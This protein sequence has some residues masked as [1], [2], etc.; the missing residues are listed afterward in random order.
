MK[1]KTFRM[2]G[3][4]GDKKIDIDNPEAEKTIG[5]GIAIAAVTAAALWGI[6]KIAKIFKK[7]KSKA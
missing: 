1:D 3:E 7:D 5:K 2:K 6:S 4:W